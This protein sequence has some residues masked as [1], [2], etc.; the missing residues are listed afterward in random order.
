MGVYTKKNRRLQNKAWH[1]RHLDTLP[2]C[3]WKMRGLPT[4]K[5]YL[6]GMIAKDNLLKNEHILHVHVMSLKKSGDSTRSAEMGAVSLDTQSIMNE[7][8]T[9]KVKISSDAKVKGYLVFS[10]IRLCPIH[11]RDGPSHF[12]IRKK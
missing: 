1:Y 2:V 5:L 11:E 4:I 12:F 3:T 8:P 10:N 9:I 7:I 6:H